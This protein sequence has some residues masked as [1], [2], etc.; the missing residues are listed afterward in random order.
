MKKPETKT[1]ITVSAAVFILYLCIHYWP[2]VSAI[3]GTVLAA[4]M[5]L[6]IGG[7]FAYLINILMSFYERSFFPRS[8]KKFICR[9]RRAICLILAILSLIALTALITSLI[10][11]QLVS[12]IKLLVAEIPIAIQNIISYLEQTNILSEELMQKL[13]AINF[14]SEIRQIAAT[15]FSGIGSILDLFAKFISS[16]ISGVTTTFLALVFAIYLL[17]SKDKLTVQ[18][19][20]LAK[21]YLKENHCLKLSYVLSVANDCF[22][23]FVVGQCIDAVI[24]GALC[25]V[26][27]LLLR[28]PYALMIGAVIA[29]TAL[30]PIVG[31]FLG[32]AIGAFLIFMQSPVQAL[33]FLIFLIILQQLE[34]DLIYPRVVGSSIGLPGIWVLAAVTVGGGVFGILG[35]LIGVPIAATVYRLLKN[36]LEQYERLHADTEPK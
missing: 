7:I 1:I 27:M 36:D 4:L 33:I 26:G 22:H 35:M 8:K 6:F 9:S 29:F 30:I 20:R 28:L 16:F 23:R 13:S 2:N 18:I 17:L 5:P 24:L 34:G 15:V 21:R 10:V 12:C 19:T 32:G 14:Q 11:P 25:T 3:L 31:A